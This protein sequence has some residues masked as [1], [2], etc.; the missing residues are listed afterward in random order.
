[1]YYVGLVENKPHLVASNHILI[2]HKL[3]VHTKVEFV[4][5]YYQN[6]KAM[7]LLTGNANRIHMPLYHPWLPRHILQQYTDY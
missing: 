4:S 6:W 2:G 7:E 5:P 1:M 3:C